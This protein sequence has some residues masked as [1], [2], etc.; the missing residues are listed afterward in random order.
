MFKVLQIKDKRKMILGRN[1]D[2][3]KG[4]KN[5][6]NSKYVN[7]YKRLSPL[8][9]FFLWPHLWYIEVEGQGSNWSTAAT[10]AIAAAMPDL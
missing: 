3:S 5:D 2:I 8:I 9:F 10:Y 1:L 4:F 7:K 6:R